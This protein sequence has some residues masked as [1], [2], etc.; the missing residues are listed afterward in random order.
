MRVLKYILAVALAFAAMLPYAFGSGFSS[1]QESESLQ[2]LQ[3]SEQA[4]ETEVNVGELL[5][6]HIGDSFGWHITDWGGKH[7]TI[8][9]PCIV[10]SRTSGWHCFMSSNV[11]H[12]HEYEGLFIASEG[13]F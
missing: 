3:A 1:S 11:E 12:G 2:D 6:G 5:F 4:R 9:L 8:P 7:V 13:N 10:Y